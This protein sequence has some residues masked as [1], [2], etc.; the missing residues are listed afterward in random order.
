MSKKYDIS[1]SF[2]G[3]DR[4]IARSIALKLES[5]S[6]SVF[7]DDF[8][9]ANLWGKDLY[10]HLVEVYK[11]N[12]KYCLMIVSDAYQSKLWTTHERKAA[13]ARAFK[14]NREYILPLR[15]DD[16]EVPGI[17]DTIGYID[18]RNESTDSIVELI[19]NKLWGDLSKDL[20]IEKLKKQ[21]ESLYSRIMLFCVLAFQPKDHEYYE[22]S[23]LAQEI[24]DEA[25]GKLKKLKSDFQINAPNI[26]KLILRQSTEI[27]GAFD[28][29]LHR[30]H[31]LLNIKN[32]KLSSYD[33]IGR[34]PEED[35]N[36][37]YSFLNRMKIFEN[38]DLNSKKKFTPNDIIDCWKSAEQESNQYY[39][40]PSSYRHKSDR[41]P[42][43]FNY[44]TLNSLSPSGIKNGA[45]VKTYKSS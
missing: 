4:E 20:G 15:L 21:F 43:V 30:A 16:I 39:S 25:H 17:L 41:T 31:F 35:F 34:I 10:E 40:N 36:K 8:E 5:K 7:Y 42:L 2:A 3:E 44:D 12:S 11:D 13:Q 22:K 6:I 28:N 33:F 32:P 27:L 38:Y 37:I 29:I 1:I 24:G 9:K 19:Q 14:E 18:F 26:D 45:I 23:D